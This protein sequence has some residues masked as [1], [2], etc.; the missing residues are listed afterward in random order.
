LNNPTLGA[1]MGAG[2]GF[3]AVIVSA[4]GVWRWRHRRAAVVGRALLRSRAERNP[5]GFVTASPAQQL[6]STGAATSAVA[7]VNPLAAAAVSSRRGFLPE[8]AWVSS[9]DR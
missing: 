2:V 5:S 8:P 1:I 7:T 9:A 6:R 4:L 3:A